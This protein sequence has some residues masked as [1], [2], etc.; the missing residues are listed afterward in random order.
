MDTKRFGEEQLKKIAMLPDIQHTASGILYRVIEENESAPPT[1][2][3]PG[4]MRAEYYWY[5][6]NGEKITSSVQKKY[7]VEEGDTIWYED[8]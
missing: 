4:A 1:P 6:L 8:K 5:F 2:E 3:I 7:R